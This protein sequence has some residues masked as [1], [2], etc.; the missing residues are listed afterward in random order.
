LRLSESLE[1][2]RD[3]R[4][5]ST[6]GHARGTRGCGDEDELPPGATG[7]DFKTLQEMIAQGIQDSETGASK[8]EAV[9]SD[10]DADLKRHRELM[11]KRREQEAAARE[12][13]REAARQR[14]R[15]EE[16]EQQRRQKAALE[17]QQGEEERKRQHREELDHQ[18][19]CE[20]AAAIRIQAHWRGRRSRA[21]TP[22]E[23]PAV[24]AKLHSHPWYSSSSSSTPMAKEPSSSMLLG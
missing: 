21:G 7:A 11:R 2:T 18:C 14:R 19:R 12:K 20:L 6:G 4:L 23:A 17:Q 24:L 9:L 10:D 1:T 13:E 8:L 22:V 5:S 15:R 16:E 3:E